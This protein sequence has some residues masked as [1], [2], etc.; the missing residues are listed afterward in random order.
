MYGRIPDEI[1]PTKASTNITY[2]NAFDAEF[3]LLLRERRSTTLLSMQEAT[4]EVESNML[5]SDRLKTRSDKEKTKQREDAPTSSNPTTYDPQ[6]EYMTN[7]LKDLTSKIAKLKWESKQPNIPFQGAGNRNQNQFRR[8]NDVPQVMQRERRNVNDQRVLPPFQNN[9]IEEMDTDN[10]VVDDTIVIF[11]EIDRY[12]SH[13]TQQEYEV[14]QLSNQFD[15]QIGE[16]GVIQGQTKKKYDLRTRNGASKATTSYQGKQAEAPPNPN[17][18]KGMPSKTQS[19][20]I[21]N[22]LPPETKKVDKPL[23]SFSLVHELR[24]IKILIPLI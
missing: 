9:Q 23:T 2:A 24:K 11:N 6:L 22:T 3:S 19:S 5:A 12:T 18:N 4:I 8:P 17:P 20:P 13:L 10:D 16:E 7:T 1:K 14:A 21:S 15:D